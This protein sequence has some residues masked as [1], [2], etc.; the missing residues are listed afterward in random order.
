LGAVAAIL[1]AWAGFGKADEGSSSGGDPTRAEIRVGIDEGD[2]RG[3]DNRALQA[4]VD[5]VARLGG[6]TVHI[7]P[8]RYEMRNALTLRD[9]VRVV[10]EPGRTVL[11]A[12]DGAESR[13]ACDGD[14]N[15]R[16][17]TLDDPTKFRVGDGVSIQDDTTGGFAVTTATLTGRVDDRSFTISAPLYLDYMVA[18]KA[19]ARLAF[20]IVGGSGVRDP[21]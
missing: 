20:P 9:Y 7:G 8:G 1:A 4:A 16:Q 13:L 15:E 6:G 12:C 10:G 21:A 14:C 5:L 3:R 11:V 17:V 18:K 19:T 2:I